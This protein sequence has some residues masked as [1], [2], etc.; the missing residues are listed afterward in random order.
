[1]RLCLRSAKS[2]V[3]DIKRMTI[4]VLME[5]GDTWD[6]QTTTRDYV[7]YDQTAKRQRPPWGPMTENV[8][9][10]EAFIAWNASKRLG[11]YSKP[12]EQFLDDC[13]SADG[14]ADE[15]VDPTLSGVGPDSSLS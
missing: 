6:V 9:L 5:N 15:F 13:V 2:E 4:T 12:W 11:H 7:A 14:K 8:A 3:P 1:M 10:W